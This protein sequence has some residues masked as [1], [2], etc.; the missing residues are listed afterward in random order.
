V[1]QIGSEFSEGG[2]GMKMLADI[3]EQIDSGNFRTSG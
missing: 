2:T 3:D 1:E